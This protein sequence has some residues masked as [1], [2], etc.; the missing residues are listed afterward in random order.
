LNEAQRLFAISLL[1]GHQPDA[2]F[3]DASAP[4]AYYNQMSANGLN[5][6]G[7]AGYTQYAAGQVGEDLL[8]LFGTT[9]VQ[10]SAQRSGY[11]SADPSRQG[12]AWGYGALTVGSIAMNAI[13]GEGKVA[14]AVE[15]EGVKVLAAKTA[16]TT[17]ARTASG[18][19]YSVAFETTLK[20][21]SYPGVLRPAHF[22]EANEALLTAMENDPQLA[23]MMENLGVDLERTPTGLAPRTSPTGW[24]WHHA[25]QPGVM[26]LVPRS[27]HAPGSIFQDVFH[28]G[29]QG[30]YSIW[31]E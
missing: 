25:Q 12:A 26:Q 18:D 4:A 15:E 20:P 24:T 3:T 5:Q 9:S 30:G 22:Q 19:F 10:Q 17:A 8:D 29:G 13:P 27:Q 23:E 1:S 6:G 21:T 28:P 31:G 7:I 14:T 11:A 16:E 2:G